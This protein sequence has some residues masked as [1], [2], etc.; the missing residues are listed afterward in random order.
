MKRAAPMKRTPFSGGDRSARS[1]YQQNREQRLADRALAAIKSAAATR[2]INLEQ[3]Q[4]QTKAG[5]ARAAIKVDACTVVTKPVPKARPVRSEP[6]RRAVASLPCAC[7]GLQGYSQHAH[8]NAGKGKGIKV[9][10][11][12]AMPLCA[13]TPG[14]RGCHSR[15]DSYELFDGKR[16]SHVLAGK[17]WAAETRA[18]VLE[19]GLWPERLAKEGW[20]D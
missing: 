20:D 16:E 6:Y 14:R 18:K 10:D 4:A 7:C 1:V 8:E 5:Q 15:F 17:R 19:L 9:S 11:L 2:Q 3:K 13:D 12:N